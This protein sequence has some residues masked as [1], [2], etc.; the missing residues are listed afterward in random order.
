MRYF[1][2]ASIVML[3]IVQVLGRTQLSDETPEINSENL[4]ILLAPVL[5]VY[6]VGV[7]YLLLDNM[8]LPFYELRYVAIGIFIFL[9]W[10]PMIFSILSG[11]KNPLA[12]P[13]YR[14]DV[15]QNSSTR[16]LQPSEMMMSDIPW[17]VAWY[18]DRQCVWRTLYVNPTA[19]DARQWQESFFAI[20]DA[21]KPINV[22]YLTP[23]SLD[24]RFQSQWLKAGEGSWGDFII[25]TLL[26]KQVPPGFPLKKMPPG[27]L[28]EQ[29]LLADW[30]RW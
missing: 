5:V 28:P 10:L 26:L 13:P 7:F 15:V 4:L 23:E 17:A 8:K 6:G 21:L 29:L 14:P 22:L 25:S 9:L 24:S 3:A 1:V 30:V 16:I 2:V 27:Y 18:G 20:N 19:G 12:Y 11:K